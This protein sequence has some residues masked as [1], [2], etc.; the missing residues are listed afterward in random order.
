MSSID[1]RRGWQILFGILLATLGLRVGHFW[2]PTF[3][4]EGIFGYVAQEVLRGYLPLETV[5]ENK[6]VF[7]FY[8]QALALAVGG[9]GSIAS[10]RLLATL[11][12]LGSLVALYMLLRDQFDQPTALTGTALLGFHWSLIGL[13]GNYYATEMYAMPPCILACF[14]LWR[15]CERGHLGYAAGGGLMLSLA[16]WTR[17]TTATFVIAMAI[18]ILL[19]W[20]KGNR[21]LGF[22]SYG[23]AGILAS[24]P[25]V[26]LYAI[27]GK[28]QLLHEAYLAASG[29]QLVVNDLAGTPM[30]KLVRILGICFP[31]MAVL[32]LALAVIPFAGWWKDRRTIYLVC[33]LCAGLLSFV[34]TAH[35]LIKQTHQF[36][37]WLCALAAWLMLRIFRSGETQARLAGLVVACSLTVSSALNLPQYY[38]LATGDPTVSDTILVSG[39]KVSRWILDSTPPEAEIFV[40]GVEWEIYFRSQRRSPVRQINLANLLVTAMAAERSEAFVAPLE[41]YQQEIWTSLTQRPP[42]VLVVVSGVKDHG[43]SNYWLPG[44]FE[45]MVDTEYDYQ[46]Y[47]EPYYVFRRKASAPGGPK[48]G[49]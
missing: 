11:T 1:N 48:Q 9:F 49:E 23:A 31:H 12:G 19:Y 41:E 6:G 20:Q 25:F 38:R 21:W 47:Q 34:A 10:I 3:R 32:L 40:W 33:W 18:Y 15:A 42:E 45:K 29:L 8:E 2:A 28:L 46:F 43:L 5:F 22:V 13:Q 44:K 14:W 35:Y 36:L 37:P 7:F 24:V 30:S 27:P 16:V 17:L 4:D 26:L 39:E